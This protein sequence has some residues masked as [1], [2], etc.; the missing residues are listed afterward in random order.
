MQVFEPHSSDPQPSGRS[1]LF[2]FSNLDNGLFFALIGL[3]LLPIW[4]FEY[5]PLQDGPIH[6]HTADVLHSFLTDSPSI[7]QDYYIPNLQLTP[8]WTTQVILTGL[9]F[10]ASPAIAQKLLLSLYVIL[11]PLVVRYALNGV[12]PEAP[13]FLAFL[14]FPLCYNLT[15]N[16]GFYNFAYSLVVF[17]FT[18]GYW[19][20][21]R[22]HPSQTGWL[23]L[24][25]LGLYFTHLFSFIVFC[26]VVGVLI[27]WQGMS[28]FF[29]SHRGDPIALRRFLMRTTLPT[30][31]ALLPTCL[32]CLQFLSQNSTGSEG[33]KWV[34]SVV[35][36]L[37][38]GSLITLSSLVSYSWFELVCAIS[39]GLVLIGLTAYSLW[40]R[41]MPRRGKTILAGN[42]LLMVTLVLVG[43]YLLAPRG[44]SGSVTIK[45]RLLLYPLLTLMLWMATG[46]YPSL[47]RRGMTGLLVSIAIAL[48]VVQTTTYGYL[49]DYWREY[50]SSAPYIEEN[51]TLL[52]INL[53]SSQASPQAP[54]LWRPPKFVR[55]WQLNP[56][57]N[58]SGHIAV[59]RKA[60][61]LNNYQANEDYFP[62]NFRPELNPFEIMA[63][64]DWR[65]LG[66]N[67][68]V[69]IL[70]YAAKT[71]RPIDYVAIWQTADRPLQ[72]Q[73]AIFQQLSTAYEL[74]YTSPQR[75]YAR[76]YRY[77]G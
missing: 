17:L 24:L 64:D 60:V 56:F 49:N 26:I 72:E 59:A 51:A 42:G 9:L 33:P 29:G 36:N 46:R 67:L 58:V 4:L 25:I 5:L 68:H 39:I 12:R 13:S 18:L 2:R 45:D 75:G 63:T 77:K 47:I 7:F 19:L 20:R 27:F 74:I 62:V 54:N 73:E 10:I 23:L 69:D 71:G 21:H 1:V 31:M 57:I 15:F 34:A 30:G 55:P 44:L 65:L 37:R 3:F 52:A 28:L 48:L 6:A 35:D 41:G 66:K 40:R 70:G 11:L 50:T 16:M 76:L 8:N 61:L 43:V 53:P 38:L 22:N 14:A 32:I